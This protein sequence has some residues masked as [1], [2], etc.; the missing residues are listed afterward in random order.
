MLSYVS[1]LPIEDHSGGKLCTSVMIAH[2][3]LRVVVMDVHM[4]HCI[5]FAPYA[6]SDIP[7]ASGIAFQ[8]GCCLARHVCDQCI[9]LC[10]GVRVPRSG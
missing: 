6:P 9:V 5:R 2:V 8:T 4:R 7:F 3:T 1:F 10:M